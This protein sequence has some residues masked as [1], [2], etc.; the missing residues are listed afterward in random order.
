MIAAAGLRPPP[1]HFTTLAGRGA[2]AGAARNG[3]VRPVAALR[4]PGDP[5]IGMVVLP[6][7]DVGGGR[8]NMARLPTSEA[9]QIERTA[10]L[11]GPS[12]YRL[13]NRWRTLKPGPR[14]MA[15]PLPARSASTGQLPLQPSEIPDANVDRATR[16]TILSGYMAGRL[17]YDLAA[18]NGA[19]ETGPV[20]FKDELVRPR[21]TGGVVSLPLEERPPSG[22]APHDFQNPLADRSKRLAGGYIAPPPRQ[23][24]GGNAIEG[25]HGGAASSS[26]SQETPSADWF[27]SGRGPGTYGAPEMPRPA[28][29]GGNILPLSNARAALPAQPAPGPAYYRPCDIQ[30]DLPGAPFAAMSS[31]RFPP[32]GPPRGVGDTDGKRVEGI[33]YL[34]PRLPRLG[35]SFSLGS[36]TLTTDAREQIRRSTEPSAA[37]Y[38]ALRGEGSIA[39][40]MDAAPSWTMAGRPYMDDFDPVFA[41]PGP[42]TYLPTKGSLGLLGANRLSVLGTRST[43]RFAARAAALGLPYPETRPSDSPAPDAYMLPTTNRG[44]GAFIGRGAPF[45]PG[46]G[47]ISPREEEKVVYRP[48]SNLPMVTRKGHGSSIAGRIKR[49]NAAKRAAVVRRARLAMLKARRSS[50]ASWNG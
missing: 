16:P 1:D 22:A 18:F 6:D 15:P 45:I 28:V 14:M 42:A 50:A 30:P 11:P 39:S 32:R 43:V 3:W 2:A 49:V 7:A 21:I 41:G 8:V 31:V 23:D 33:P 46:T 5:G 10:S 27:A 40:G 9:L 17:A 35:Q 48:V 38:D 12:A 47:R 13:P 34:L 26:S 24:K 25:R 37:H 44:I 29:P 19:S 36:R 20:Q 4:P